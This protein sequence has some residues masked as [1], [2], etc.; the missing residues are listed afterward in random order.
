MCDSGDRPAARERN[1]LCYVRCSKHPCCALRR[2][3]GH[4]GVDKIPGLLVRS[5]RLLVGTRG[6]QHGPKC[7]AGP[8]ARRRI[9]KLVVESDCCTQLLQR[10]V[11][12]AKLR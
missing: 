11:V 8:P 12:P 1:D 4:E 2:E 3:G 10:F 6:V 7:C 9:D 5:R